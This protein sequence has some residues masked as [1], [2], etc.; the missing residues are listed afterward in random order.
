MARNSSGTAT[1]YKVA[2]IGEILWDIFPDGRKLGGAPANFS[3]VA[4]ALGSEAYPVSAVGIDEDGYEIRKVLKNLKLS[5]NYILEDQ[6]HETGQVE[7]ILSQEGVPGYVIKEN[8]A[9]DYLELTDALLKLAESLNAVCFGTLAQRNHISRN[10]IRNF[11]GKVPGDHIRLL[12]INLRLEYYDTEII[13]QS[14]ELCNWLKLNDQELKTVSD[15]FG[16]TGSMDQCLQKL[17]DRFNLKLIALTL[18]A[19]GSRLITGQIDHGLGTESIAVK[20]TVGAGDAF[21]ATL[22]T[23]ALA[24]HPH[25]ICHVKSAEMASFLCQNFGATPPIP[26]K[27]KLI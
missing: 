7:V 15:L 19:K 25:T 16:F 23:A 18:G 10:T 27:Y 6:R 22:V 24:G 13:E 3:Y 2:G 8:V 17:L 11:I 14:L 4:H 9:W 26:S 21:S 5:D 12:D 1:A 20:D